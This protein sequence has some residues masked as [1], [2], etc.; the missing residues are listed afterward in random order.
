MAQT[1]MSSRC[2]QSRRNLLVTVLFGL[3]CTGSV[4][5]D[6]TA[7]PPD[8]SANERTK[9]EAKEAAERATAETKVW[10]IALDDRDQ[11]VAVVDSQPGLRW[12]WS[13][14]GRYYGGVYIYTVNQRPVA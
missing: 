8:Q 9:L 12:S 13:N 7:K 6:D 10:E 14:D 5:A 4:A 2:D 3:A 1:S 11:T